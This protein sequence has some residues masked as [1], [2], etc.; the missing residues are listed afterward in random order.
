[1][2]TSEQQISDA[3]WDAFV[4][5]HPDAA[6][7][8]LSGW[9][10]LKSDFGWDSHLAAVTDGDG[11]IR[12]G[13]LLLF[14]RIAGITFAYCPRGPLT[15]WQD[16]TLTERLLARIEQAA[17][18]RGAAFVKIEPSLAD[19]PENR[20]LLA[21]FGYQ[22]S[23]QTVQPP[24]TI[25]LDI[26]GDEQEILAQMKSKWRY[27]IRLSER[28]GV[29]VRLGG[30]EALRHFQ[31]LMETTGER[32]GFAVHSFD[33]YRTAFARL[34]P[35]HGAF[36]YAEY[37]GQVL[38]SIV[39][40]RCGPMA[41]Y[42]WGASSDAERNRMPNH[43]LQWAAIRW[44]KEQGARRYDFWGIPDEIGQIAMGMGTGRPVP[45]EEIPV[46]VAA[47]P[48]GDLWGVFRFKQGFGGVVERTVGAWDRPLNPPLYRLYL[49]G[50]ALRQARSEGLTPQRTAAETLAALLPPR[51][52]ASA[53]SPPDLRPVDSPQAWRSALA[54][55][56]APHLLQSW[57]WGELKAQ[58]GWQAQRFLLADEAGAEQA[59]K[60]EAAFQYLWRQPVGS[61]PLRV[62]Y[63]PK[64]PA[65]NWADP[66]AAERTLAAVEEAARRNRA[67]FV[68]IDPDVESDSL[69][70]RRL[71][72]LLRRR[73]WRFSPEQIQFK[74]TAVTRLDVDEEDLLASFKS[75]WR[76]NIRLSE[77]RGIQVR[78][79]GPA[80][81]AGFY[82]LYAETGA[83]D[84]FLVRPFAYYESVC[85]RFLAAQ[86]EAENPA[87]GALFLA[88]HPEES[89]PVAA[90]FVARYGDRAWYLYGASSQARR[91]DMP[92]HTLQ[93]EAMRWAKAAGCVHYDWWG[94]PTAPD[95][96]ED[97]LQGVWR[98]KEGFNAELRV[99]IGAW[100]WSPRPLLWRA[101]HWAMPLLL[102]AMRRRHGGESGPAM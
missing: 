14:R 9:G 35:Q 79:G 33:Y 80:D 2:P 95:D 16:S 19:S 6:F 49:G 4:E 70:G 81:L 67:L 26:G 36:F 102:D 32:D 39:V 68:K 10:K 77:R 47:F 5:A 90:I 28:K 21:S 48:A 84:G 87:G 61:L 24:S 50:V 45:A 13:A 96:P 85:S 37:E 69:A 29:E 54:A 8:Q 7:L 20:T 78:L 65:V 62:A 75:K 94:A 46:D 11:G 99:H 57:E 43:A 60:P 98:F 1:M 17:R 59:G 25:T 58:T 42:V 31:Q 74:N 30:Q 18:E 73:G 66:A 27:N 72:A 83:R 86:E 52:P 91:R 44:A 76:Y 34:T 15:D 71:V 51:Q 89:S 82:A 40:L 64:G 56:P 53:T 97:S 63:V 3:A 41:W 12:A 23:P 22:S 55:L 92:N 100:D 101:Y 93:W 88:E 38:A